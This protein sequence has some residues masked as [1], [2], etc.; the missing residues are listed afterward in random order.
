MASLSSVTDY[1]SVKDLSVR[2]VIGV[3][4][5]ERDDRADPARQR[6]Y[7][8]GR[9]ESRGE[10]RPGR[11]TRLLRRG[12]DH[13]GRPARRQVPPDRD[14]R[15]ARRRAPA[16]RLPAV[17]AP[18]RAPQAHH[19]RPRPARRRQDAAVEHCRRQP[20]TPRRWHSGTSWPP[21]SRRAACTA[22][23]QHAVQVAALDSQASG[24]GAFMPA[25]TA[26]TVPW[27][28]SSTSAG[29]ASSAACSMKSSG[30]WMSTM[31][32]RSSPSR[33]SFQSR[34]QRTPSRL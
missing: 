10:R 7:G 19:Q 9:A 13:R 3:H 14:R 32:T 22:G 25:P 1:V 11:R 24:A 18:P 29:Y 8:D 20:A 16:R 4:A 12:G 26:R 2:A 31:S 28:R 30:S 5:W 17:L 27:A 15:R 6:G 33:S 34:L 21:P 23:H